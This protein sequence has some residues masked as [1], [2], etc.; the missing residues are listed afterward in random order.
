M[1]KIILK[2]GLRLILAPEKSGTTATVLVLV[3]AGSEYETKKQNGI[4]HFLEH[5]VFKGTTKRP[6]AAIIASEL[7]SL[8]AICNAFTGQEYTG[9]WAKIQSGKVKNVLDIVS[10]LYLNPIFNA[11]EIDKERG[12]IIEEINL[13]ED[14]PMRRIQDLFT[15]LMYGD[16]PAGWDVGGEKNIIRTLQRDDFVVYRAKHYIAPATNVVIAGNFHEAEV[17]KM[18]KDTFGHLPRKKKV[19]KT[20]TKEA[21]KKPQ[22]LLKHKESDQTHLVLGV[23]AFDTFDSRRWALQVLANHLGG[24][25]SSRLFQR[26][27]E[28]LG[29]AYYVRAGADLS[30]DHGYLGIS[31]GV[32]HKKMDDVL[33]AILE[34]CIKLKT[35]P[36]SLADLKKTKDH[37]IGN[38]LISLD[39]SDEVANFYGGQEIMTGKVT[40]PR[41]VIKKIQAVTAKEVQDVAKFIFQNKKLNMTIIG[42]LKD[43]AHLEKLL[44]F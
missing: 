14:M 37:L 8:G 1:K 7:D 16:Q 32:D 36:I 31:A 22:L 23:R 3:E 38:F 11:E 6:T 28:E 2:N 43:K 15:Q 40:E 44:R 4:S 21:Q 24:G 20:K 13:H 35:Q 41:K 27:R 39:T 33:K 19:I 10:D 26:V 30:L 25:M 9:Y 34:E 12:V 17:V 42:P 29:A 18:I 5:L